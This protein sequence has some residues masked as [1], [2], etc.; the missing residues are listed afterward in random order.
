MHVSVIST[1]VRLKLRTKS[2]EESHNEKLNKATRALEVGESITVGKQSFLLTSNAVLPFSLTCL[3]CFLQ[4]FSSGFIFSLSFLV[5]LKMKKTHPNHS[6]NH[7]KMEI[8]FLMIT[9]SKIH[10]CSTNLIIFF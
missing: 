8:H 9:A 10:C 3:L 1:V 2:K 5:S 4:L 7:E 6:Y